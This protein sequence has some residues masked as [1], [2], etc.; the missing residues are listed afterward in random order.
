MDAALTKHLWRSPEVRS[1]LKKEA[2][3]LLLF[4]VIYVGTVALSRYVREKPMLEG[5][6]SAT[7]GAA[8]VFLMWLVSA[9]RTLRA[10]L[11]EN[12]LLHR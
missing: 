2:G 12:D 10:V 8:G 4:A 3:R 7:L 9:V 1:A 5:I 6:F 11:R